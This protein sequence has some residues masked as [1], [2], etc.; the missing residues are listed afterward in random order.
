MGRTTSHHVVN[1]AIRKPC[2]DIW[3][4]NAGR[5]NHITESKLIMRYPASN[6]HHKNK[7]GIEMMDNIV[8]QFLGGI[9]SLIT[10]P[11]NGY[12][13]LL[14]TVCLDL[15]YQVGASTGYSLPFCLKTTPHSCK[16]VLTNSD[17]CNIN[18]HHVLHQQGRKILLWLLQA[19]NPCVPKHYSYSFP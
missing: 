14:F 15:A 8:S 16:F 19:P 17:N 11:R 1:S 10:A 4:H 13:V 2:I 5:D 12:S 18:F 9:C 3:I 6:T 7:L